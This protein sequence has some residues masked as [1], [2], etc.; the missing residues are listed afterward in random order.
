MSIFQALCGL[1]RWG[2]V[3]F[4][5]GHG[6]SYQTFI[7]HS[8]ERRKTLKIQQAAIKSLQ[9]TVK[10]EMDICVCL[11]VCVSLC[12]LSSWI[13]LQGFCSDSVVSV[14][15]CRQAA[16][17]HTWRDFNNSKTLNPSGF[18]KTSNPVMPQVTYEKQQRN[19]THTQT[20]W[21]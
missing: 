7:V 3:I 20:H 13:G 11:C 1:V 5:S 14:A 6:R 21:L 9:D 12:F 8:W 10:D 2:L 17:K 19:D 18:Y 15:V 16:Q 4:S